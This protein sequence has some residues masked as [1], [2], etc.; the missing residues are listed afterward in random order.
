MVRKTVGS[1]TPVTEL[2]N[3]FSLNVQNPF[4]QSIQFTSE[5][6]LNKVNFTLTDINGRLIKKWFEP[7]IQRNQSHTLDIP[8]ALENGFFILNIQSAEGNFTE[9]LIHQN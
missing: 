2:K 5:I 6:S 9:K 3:N 7:F 1:T 8:S 4:N